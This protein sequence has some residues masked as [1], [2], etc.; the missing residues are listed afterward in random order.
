M[1]NMIHPPKGFRLLRRILDIRQPSHHGIPVRRM[2]PH[3]ARPFY[4]SPKLRRWFDDL[5]R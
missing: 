4:V 1:V 2:T 3:M 5:A